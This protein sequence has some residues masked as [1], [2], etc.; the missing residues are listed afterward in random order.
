MYENDAYIIV[1]NATQGQEAK[2]QVLS[3]PIVALCVERGEHALR[4]AHVRI[5]PTIH[6]HIRDEYLETSTLSQYT[7]IFLFKWL[8][9]FDHLCAHCERFQRLFGRQTK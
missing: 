8:G 1:I 4:E 2:R 3:V 9:S 6:L 5:F 7:L